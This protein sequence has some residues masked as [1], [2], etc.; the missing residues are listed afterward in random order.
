METGFTFCVIARSEATWQ[1]VIFAAV[2][3]AVLCTARKTDSH[4]QFANWSRNDVE[5]ITSQIDTA[6]K[7]DW[8]ADNER[9][10]FKSSRGTAGILCVFQSFTAKS[11]KERSVILPA[12]Y[13]GSCVQSKKGAG[14]E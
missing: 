7:I 2:S 14:R 1:S 3:G 13:F 5:I 11:W 4:D 9:F 12:R 8:R 6:E 10:S